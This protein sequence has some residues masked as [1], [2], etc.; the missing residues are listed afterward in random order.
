MLISIT[1]CLESLIH[2]VLT[3]KPKRWLCD[4]FWPSPQRISPLQAY[5]LAG[6]SH[7]LPYFG[8]L[9]WQS[10]LLLFEAKL[11][12]R[13]PQ[14]KY[15]FFFCPSWKGLL[16]KSF[17]ILFSRSHCNSLMLPLW[18][19]LARP[20]PLMILEVLDQGL[21]WYLRRRSLKYGLYSGYFEVISWNSTYPEASHSKPQ[22]QTFSFALRFLFYRYKWH[23]LLP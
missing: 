1:S 15:S 5:W 6:C 12:S 4:L 22:R 21:P 14:S 9:R 8:K 13:F 7:S 18:Q 16:P 23:E 19:T 2:P 3:C 20:I 11:S 10:K 17:S